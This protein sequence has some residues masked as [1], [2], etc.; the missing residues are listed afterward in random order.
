[1][2]FEERYTAWLDDALDERERDAFER[3]LPDRAAAE[4][5]RDGW[6]KL[7]G[8]MR[9]AIGPAILPNADFLNSQV[10]AEIER[11]TT[12]ESGRTKGDLGALQAILSG[13]F[14]PAR[15]LVL[16]G[17]FLA[18][19]AGVLGVW[20]IGRSGTSVNEEA[21]I[22]RVLAARSNDPKVYA[23]AFGAPGRGTVLWL[24]NPGFIPAT[25]RLK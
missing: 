2:S 3:A 19:L 25:E 16:A 9:E 23:Y 24:E 4:R 8:E 13:W 7:R 14:A 12:P 22:S 10:L 5:E 1:M 15:R 11:T 6:R 17:S 21:Y 18:I 20:A